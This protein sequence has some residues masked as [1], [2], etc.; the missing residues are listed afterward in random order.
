VWPAN[1]ELDGFTYGHL[2][3]ID[4]ETNDYR[5]DRDTAWYLNW[6]ARQSK[7]SPQPY[8][9]LASVLR[10]EGHQ[11][12]VHEILYESKNRELENAKSWTEW[13]KLFLLWLFIGYGHKYSMTMGWFL[14]LVVIGSFV[15]K[16]PPLATHAGKDKVID[17]VFFS[18]DM[19][20]PLIELDK[21]HRADYAHGL[22]RGKRF[23]F[24]VHTIFGYLLASYL[25]AGLS[26]LA[27]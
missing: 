19:L 21:R 4:S 24:Y 1:L 25:I 10:R 7:Y 15:Y 2:G 27:K 9:Y 22:A 3:G 16:P 12:R 20:L 17:R 18:L 23:Y 11:D 8:E 5:A 6:L 26:G 13:M 14:L